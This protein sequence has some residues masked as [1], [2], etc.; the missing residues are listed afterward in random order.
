VQEL[1]IGLKRWQ[2]GKHPTASCGAKRCIDCHLGSRRRQAVISNRGGRLIHEFIDSNVSLRP[3][4]HAVYG[5][6]G[7]AAVQRIR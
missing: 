4:R 5:S 3:R 6:E 1:L 7:V 2:L